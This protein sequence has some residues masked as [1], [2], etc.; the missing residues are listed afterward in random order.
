VYFIERGWPIMI[1]IK[2]V[3]ALYKVSRTTVQKWM[4]QGLPYSKVGRL[5][6]F[7]AGEVAKWVRGA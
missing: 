2:E 6:R 5:V 3:M 4:K 7:D 1:T